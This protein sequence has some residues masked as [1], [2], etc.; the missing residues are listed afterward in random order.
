MIEDYTEGTGTAVVGGTEQRASRSLVAL[1]WPIALVGAL[2]SLIPLWLGDSRVMMGVAVLGLTFACYAVGFNLIFGSTGQLFLCVGALA[3]IGGY[4]SAILAD[5][6]GL[7]L[8]L[9]ILLATLASS[10]FG[11]LLSWIAVRRSLGVI[12]TGIITLI[13]SLVF[14]N[15]LL[16]A[17]GVTG[18]DGGFHIQ[19]GAD[20][21]LRQTIPPYY[22]MLALVLIFLLTHGLLRRSH[23]GWAFR[24]LRDDEVAAELAGVNVA[25]YRVTAAVIGAAMLGLAGSLFAL[26]EGTISP[27]T[28]GFAQV[29]VETMVLLA[30]GGIGTLF[31][32]VLGAAVFTVI[33]ELIQDL[34]QLRLLV[35]GALIIA[36]F[37]WVPRGIIPTMGD[38]I[39]R[40]NE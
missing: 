32:P 5:R 28:Y 17:A 10:V 4:G 18:G 6:V 29:D 20:T 38:L 14:G 39:R 2:L 26:T 22:L 35:Y 7:P 3:G 30:F 24:A 31:G 9:S 1:L 37:L 33:N 12:F 19:A 27:T 15:L 13:F 21:F 11:G 34:G 36:L 16:G 23:I 8:L 40:R 25:L